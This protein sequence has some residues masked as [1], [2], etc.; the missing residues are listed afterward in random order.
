MVSCLR[1]WCAGVSYQPADHH[2]T[3]FPGPR[4]LLP[5]AAG[6]V[7]SR[8]CPRRQPLHDLREWR[9]GGAGST[10]PLTYQWAHNRQV[11]PDGTD[12]KFTLANITT[13]DTGF[14][15]VGV[16]NAYGGVLSSNAYLTLHELVTNLFD[17]FEPNIHLVNWSGF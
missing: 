4:S 17:D 14:Y 7:S 3:N 13:N 9:G 12:F 2:W 16:T 11:V 15:T 10:P 6:M 8:R 1:R 5:G